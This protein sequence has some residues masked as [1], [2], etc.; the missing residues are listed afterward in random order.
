MSPNP[1]PS[2]A[3]LGARGRAIIVFVIALAV[4]VAT[5]LLGV[6]N[7]VGQRAEN[8]LLRASTLSSNV[9]PPLD[10]VSLQSIAIL[11]V[12]I[13]LIALWRSGVG[14]AIHTVLA[15]G[16]AVLSAKAL[17]NVFLERPEFHLENPGNSFPSGHAA[18]VSVL[19]M[20]LI[21]VLPSTGRWIV[22]LLS[23]PLLVT[24]SAQLLMFG[25]HRPSD[26]FGG[27]ALS[28]GTLAFGTIIRPARGPVESG[29]RGLRLVRTLFMVLGTL[30]FAVAFAV[31]VAGL[32]A[33]LN[34]RVM[35]AG[36]IAGGGAALWVLALVS[37]LRIPVRGR[38]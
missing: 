1:S 20:A 19:V 3:R 18:V 25:W 21:L 13:A 31:G 26:V 2:R 15:I 38:R 23:A 7:D 17:K 32:G 24:I 4:F 37:L 8:A 12:L 30:G 5:Y 9:P 6:Q 11:A 36:E 22:M 16:I 27:F 10:W 35:L 14:G 34:T 33:G 29:T 28:L